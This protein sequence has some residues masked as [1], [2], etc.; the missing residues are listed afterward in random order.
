[1]PLDRRLRLLGVRVASLVPVA[2]HSADSMPPGREWDLPTAS[3]ATEFFIANRDTV[4]GMDLANDEANF[5]GSRF[6]GLFRKARKAG[7]H[8]TVHAG[9]S[10]IPTSS[11]SIRSALEELGA[12]RIGHGV[13]IYKDPALMDDVAR[14]GIL[15]ELCPT[16]NL[17]TKSIASMEAYPIRQIRAAGIRVSLNAD[18]P[19]V[20]DY[21][22]T[23]E[24]QAMADLHGLDEADFAAINRDALASSFLPEKEKRNAL[25]G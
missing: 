4:I 7:L 11:Q 6:A 24:Y 12:E 8:L 9:E 5:T 17:R 15:L 21:D 14:R 13:Q 19:G 22:L 25:G 18:D 10:D 3:R 20:F 1:M 16:S 23:H 2:P